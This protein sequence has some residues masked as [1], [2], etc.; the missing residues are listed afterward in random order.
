ML[1]SLC[2]CT[3]EAVAVYSNTRKAPKKIGGFYFMKL[4]N[5][6]VVLVLPLS[7]FVLFSPLK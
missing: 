1:L 5:S 3:P 2:F 6:G 4:H 7:F